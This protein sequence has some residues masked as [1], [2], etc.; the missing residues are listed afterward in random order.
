MAPRTR[1]NQRESF[2]RHLQL[3]MDIDEE[4]QQDEDNLMNLFL[5]DSDE[6]AMERTPIVGRIPNKDRG[7]F[8]GHYRLMADYLN[9][10]PVY[11]D[12]DFERR[13]RVTKTVFFRLCNDLQTKNLHA[14][15]IQRPDA[16]GKMG[17]STPQKVT[18]ALRQLG[19][20]VSSDATNEY[21]RIG[22]TTARQTLKNFTSSVIHIYAARYLRK[23]TNED[24]K[25]ILEEN[26][27]QVTFEINQKRFQSAYYLC[28]GIY[29][30]WG[31]FIKSIP[32]ASDLATK[33]FNS[34]QE[35]FRKDIE[36]AFGSLQSK[37]H[38]LTS[39]ICNWY[40]DNIEQIVLCCIILHNMMVE[41]CSADS[42]CNP[43]STT[44]AQTSSFSIVPATLSN[45]F[46]ERRKILNSIQSERDH[47]ELT[48]A[49]IQYQWANWGSSRM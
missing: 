2:R 25:L 39:P 48:E 31:S 38:I 12:A 35:A 34:V 26:A 11:S 36:R 3:L 19:Y 46:E 28:N 47:W 37:W 5:D 43:D 42:E 21:V 16:T 45:Q 13:F 22:E 24:L 27:A 1:A 41:E 4:T 7:A 8:F 32:N 10:D 17:L 18:C 20:G 29:P 33:H 9:D 15:F 6:E 14:Y 44:T 30:S 23:P 40:Q 49:L